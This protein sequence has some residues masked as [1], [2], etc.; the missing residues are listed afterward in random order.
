[1]T[2]QLVR[3]ALPWMASIT[4]MR[5][6]ARHKPARPWAL[7]KCSNDIWIKPSGGAA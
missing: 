3:T 5:I 1:M 6:Y 7:M 4:L 2:P